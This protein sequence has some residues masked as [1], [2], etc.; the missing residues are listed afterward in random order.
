MATVSTTGLYEFDPYGTNAKNLI[1]GERQTLQTPGRD[2]FYFIIPKAAP[3]FV[4]S[5]VLYNDV[6]GIQ[7]KEGVDFLFGHYFVEAME[8]TGRPVAGSIR[9][10]NKKQTG[11]VRYNYRTLGG[12]WGFADKDILAELSSKQ[13]NPITRSWGMIAPLPASFPVVPHDQSLDDLVGSEE[14]RQAIEDLADI[15][16]EAAEGASKNHIQNFDNPHKTNKKHVGLG[17]VD[18]FKTATDDE[19]KIGQATNR[20]STP[21]GVSLAIR[22]QV[23]K[24]LEDHINNKDNPHGTDADDVGLGNVDNF[25]TATDEQ[26]IDRTRADLFLTPRGGALLIDA[27]T[28]STRL[29]ALDDE[30][31]EHIANINNP[32]Q[33]GAHDVGTFT[34]EEIEEKLRNVKVEDSPRFNGK[35]EDEWR[36][37]LPSFDDFTQLTNQLGKNFQDASNKALALSSEDPTTDSEREAS[38]L[39]AYTALVAGWGSWGVMQANG[40]ITFK[41]SLSTQP[42]Q[43]SNGLERV[44]MCDQAVYWVNNNGSIGYTGSKAIQPPDGYGTAGFVA[45]NAIDKLWASMS[46]VYLLTAS[47]KLM[48]YTAT[49]S[50]LTILESGVEAV[51]CNT[52]DGSFPLGEEAIFIQRTDG[53]I[54]PY[55]QQP[56]V[57]AAQPVLDGFKSNPNLS[58]V[59]KICVA[60]Q[61]MAFH[62]ASNLVKVYRITR[63]SGIYN[64]TAVNIPNSRSTTYQDISGSYDHIAFLLPDGRIDYIGTDTAGEC[65]VNEASGPFTAIAAGKGFTVTL[66]ATGQLQFWGDSPLNTLLPSD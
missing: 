37:S 61:Y 35:D 43:L 3:F 25:K 9:F 62:F 48:K 50:I 27:L 31:H 49:R 23:G 19:M 26:A 54:T 15:A 7:L 66:K 16:Q 34:S 12:Q 1:T 55:G 11:I 52:E 57:S 51:F 45:A 32:H 59:V 21:R 56:F 41:Q 40:T 22:E 29:D 17:D 53:T 4:D 38:A 10:L 39:N 58:T 18:N 44:S 20:F 14:I 24:A 60:N 64:L 13:Y 63:G 8:S 46:K 28:D 33:T 36:E 30:L 47:G 42:R 65:A 2:D 6:T 5:F